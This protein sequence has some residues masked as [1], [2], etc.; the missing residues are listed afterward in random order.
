MHAAALDGALLWPRTYAAYQRY[1]AM[2]DDAAA[3]H[4]LRRS[5]L[6]A[7][8]HHAVR[9]VP[10]Y[11]ERGRH[12]A[13]P[14]DPA[15][16]LATFP[17]RSKQQLQARFADHCD[18]ELR[19]EQ[20]YSVHTSGTTGI[21]FTFLTDQHHAVHLAAL[22]LALEERETAGGVFHRRILEL[23]DARHHGWFEF[24]STARGFARVGSGTLRGTEDA[25]RATV[26]RIREFRPDSVTGLPSQ[27]VE[28]VD[29]VAELGLAMPPA[30][31]AVHTTSELLTPAARARI[32]EGFQAPVRDTYAMREMG[33]IAAE[34]AFGTRH[35]MDERLWVEVVDDDGHPVADGKQGEIVITNLMNRVMPFIRYRTG[36]LGALRPA[37]GPCACGRTSDVLQLTAGRS[38]WAIE[39]PGGTKLAVL[40]LTR[41]I[42]QFPVERY[43]LVK[44]RT[45]LIEALV[46]PL[47]ACRTEDLRAME[48]L[49]RATCRQSDSSVE[50]RLR[51]VGSHDFL[52]TGSRK[53]VDF[54]DLTDR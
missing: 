25:L 12:R 17:L 32:E 2:L 41:L 15:E 5:R 30:P 50:L 44:R 33:A 20:S 29:L 14:A 46:R 43:Q 51:T 1:A 37:E 47:P 7:L 52:S 8:L 11:R 23:Y 40:T 53:Q 19:P 48:E 28:F 36:D 16:F 34:C 26:A 45:D 49:L 4:A 27:C 6:A 31:A 22:N 21:P 54:V 3:A 24:T 42:R 39:L 10:V 18:D 13:A 35:V 38:N 9:N